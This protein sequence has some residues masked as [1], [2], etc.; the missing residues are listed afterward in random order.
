DLN[1]IWHFSE[2]FRG[3][4]GEQ[5]QDAFRPTDG[6]SA[7]EHVHPDCRAV[8]RRS[9]RADAVLRRALSGHGI[10]AV[11]LPRESTR[12]R[13]LLVGADLETL[14]HGLPRFGAA[15]DAGRCQRGARLAH[16]R[17]VGPAIDRPGEATVRQ[18]GFGFRPRQ[19]GLCTRLDDHR[20]LSGGLSVGPFPHHQSGG[21]DA[22]AVGLARE[23]PELHPRVGWQAARRSRARPPPSRGQALLLPEAGAI[24]VMDRGYVDF[25]LL[26]VLHLAGAFFVTRA[27][28]KWMLI[29]SIPPPQTARPASF[30]IKPSRWTATTPP[31]IT[32]NTCGA[33][34]SGT[35]K[36]ERSWYSSPISSGCRRP[37]SPRS[38]KAAGKSNCS[39]NGSSSTCGS[40]A[41][42]AH[43]KMP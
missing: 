3:G 14:F 17:G 5:W 32:P 29:G 42:S 43:P 6:F 24:Y 41:S 19:H 7:V 39:S 11:D 13:N 23:H 12:H 34:A 1:S 15:L 28:S 40:N 30:A 37:P 4:A 21:Q 18:R 25:A 36:R 10:R 8:R 27:K 26:H 20:S 16:L 35:P 31:S 9:A 33:S 22:H 38:T 2:D